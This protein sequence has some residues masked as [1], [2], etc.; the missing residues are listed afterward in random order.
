M[1]QNDWLMNLTVKQLKAELRDR[2]C[3]SK[4]HKEYL[5]QQLFAEMEK[6]RKILENLNQG[7]YFGLDC[8]IVYHFKLLLCDK[9][10]LT[11]S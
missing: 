10:V 2:K 7:M 9:Y 6:E 4:G 11:C 1:E 8:I 5:Q 3:I